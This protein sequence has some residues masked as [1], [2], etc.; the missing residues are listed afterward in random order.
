MKKEND[1]KR[2]LTKSLV[3]FTLGVTLLMLA[4]IG[5]YFI[6]GNEVFISEISQLYNIKTLISQLLV[7]GISYYIIFITF[8]I[9]SLLQEKEIIEKYI[10]KYS[11]KFVLPLSL[12][13]AILITIICIILSNAE[14]YSEN[15]RNL[16]IVVLVITYALEGI[17]LIKKAFEENQW[18][19]EIN[20]R[21]KEKNK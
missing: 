3:G 17:V 8:Q 5:V 15:I 20:K 16:N 14:I 4:Y 18:I 11:Y 19:K 21:L 7:N 13:L 9:Y 10:K 6:E 12:I 1:V 2:V